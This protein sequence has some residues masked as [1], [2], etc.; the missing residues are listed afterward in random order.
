MDEAEL[1]AQIEHLHTDAYAWTRSCC[2]GLPDDAEEVLQ[3]VYLMV[4]DG[5]ARFEGRSEFRTWLFGVILRVAANARR[6]A[7]IRHLLLERKANDL[8]PVE[9]P[10]AGNEAMLSER[11]VKLRH[12]LATLATRQRQVLELVFYHDMTVEAAASVM[13]VSVGSARTHYA[14]GK[15][16][17]AALLSS[18]REDTQ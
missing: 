18:L 1:R 9:P 6:T 7:W 14:R 8:Q 12:A 13:G 5:R 10:E 3:T 15:T 11:G 17:L 16:R 4:L 2:R